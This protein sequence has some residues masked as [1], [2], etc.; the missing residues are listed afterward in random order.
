[1]DFE[2]EIKNVIEALTISDYFFDRN[3]EEI[4]ETGLE[5]VVARI[6]FNDQ[7]KVLTSLSGGNTSTPIFCTKSFMSL[8]NRMQ[9]SE[10]IESLWITLDRKHGNLNLKFD[11]SIIEYLEILIKYGIRFNEEDMNSALEIYEKYERR[12]DQQIEEK[13][14]IAIC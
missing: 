5:A 14:K 1:M 7:E 4:W 11:A 9:E 10:K 13:D 8:K 6:K 3:F 2:S 12:F